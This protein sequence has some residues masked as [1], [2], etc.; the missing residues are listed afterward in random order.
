MTIADFASPHV[1]RLERTLAAPRAAVWRCWT[2]PDLIQQWFCPLPWRVTEVRADLRA[3]APAS[4]ACR[5][6]AP[7]A[8]P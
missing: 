4:R 2:E 8:R 6:R 1:L 3:A 7:T 5:A